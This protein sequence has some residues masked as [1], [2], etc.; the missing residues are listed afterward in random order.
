VKI[1]TNHNIIATASRKVL[2]LKTRRCT[3]SSAAAAAFEQ[4]KTEAFSLK[5]L[6]KLKV[7]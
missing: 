6:E 3:N 4:A 5:D 1:A 7:Q 2:A